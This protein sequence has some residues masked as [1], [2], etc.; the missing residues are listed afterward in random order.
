METDAGNEFLN[1]ITRHRPTG[2]FHCDQ[3]VGGGERWGGGGGRGR[4]G[5]GSLDRSAWSVCVCFCREGGEET[6]RGRE[7]V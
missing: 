6:E 7:R 1:D 5:G 2:T 4:G 3:G